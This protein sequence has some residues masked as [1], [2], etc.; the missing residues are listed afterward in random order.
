M[1][2]MIP[3]NIYDNSIPVEIANVIFIASR[4]QVE[5]NHISMLTHEYHMNLPI[6]YAKDS[7]VAVSQDTKY[8]GTHH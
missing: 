6:S 8:V 1:R 5:M 2:T 7:N 4:M 3:Y